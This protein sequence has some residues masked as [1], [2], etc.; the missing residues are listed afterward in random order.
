[1]EEVA[2]IGSRSQPRPKAGRF[3]LTRRG[4][5][6]MYPSIRALAAP[7]FK[8]AETTR[9]PPKSYES[10]IA[11]ATSVTY[12]CTEERRAT[13]HHFMRLTVRTM[14]RATLQRQPELLGLQN[15][16]SMRAGARGVC[17]GMTALSRDTTDLVTL[18]MVHAR[19]RPTSQFPTMVHHQPLATL[20]HPAGSKALRRAAQP[21]PDFKLATIAH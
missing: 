8:R 10:T 9:W 17:D 15:C 12:D 6:S 11:P 13:Y 20:R 5:S 16:R 2:A 1:L 21:E 14:P 18:G 3:C 4:C 19:A 7:D